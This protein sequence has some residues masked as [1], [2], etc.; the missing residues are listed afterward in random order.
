MIIV[1][2]R[3][4]TTTT[5]AATGSCALLLVLIHFHSDMTRFSVHLGFAVVL[6]IEQWWCEWVGYS[7]VYGLKIFNFGHIIKSLFKINI[8][9]NHYFNQ[10]NL[11]KRKVGK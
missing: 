4:V 10:F 9:Q 1:L 3:S 6:N 5:A 8:M 7:S 2:N 11:I